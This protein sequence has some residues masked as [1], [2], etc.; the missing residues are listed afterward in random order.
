MYRAA[1]SEIPKER[2]D[3]ASRRKN[4]NDYCAVSFLPSSNIVRGNFAANVKVFGKIS[5]GSY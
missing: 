3:A 4:V 5:I 2:G 1:V